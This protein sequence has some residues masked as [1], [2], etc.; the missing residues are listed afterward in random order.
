MQVPVGT[1]CLRELSTCLNTLAFWGSFLTLS[2]LM[3]ALIM[4]SWSQSLP[5]RVLYS[6]KHSG[7]VSSIAW[8]QHQLILKSHNNLGKFSS[9]G[10][11]ALPGCQGEANYS[12]AQGEQAALGGTA[13]RVFSGPR[14]A[15]VKSQLHQPLHFFLL[16]FNYH[17]AIS[18]K[19]NH[20]LDQG[21]GYWLFS[22]NP[23]SRAWAGIAEANRSRQFLPLPALLALSYCVLASHWRPVG[24]CPGAVNV[25]V[26]GCHLKH[27]VRWLLC[28]CDQQVWHKLR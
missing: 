5:F 1:R 12:V 15:R 17:K 26:G 8:Q 20:L 18:C 10:L 22:L 6:I 19:C 24:V 25:C 14:S 2:L 28:L 3:P 11:G 27:P 4:S 21:D 16:L 7:A 23:N 9:A 13:L